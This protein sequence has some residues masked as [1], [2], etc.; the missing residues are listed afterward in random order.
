MA[1]AEAERTAVTAARAAQVGTGNAGSSDPHRVLRRQ[2]A[3]RASRLE[4][5]VARGP[6]PGTVSRALRLLGKQQQWLDVLRAVEV[7]LLGLFGLRGALSSRQ[8]GQPGRVP[9]PELAG[10][11]PAATIA[12]LAAAFAQDPARRGGWAVLV[13]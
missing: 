11:E 6:A 2:A 8:A 5:L 4:R 9:A 7:A 12:I 13:H 10:R 3:G 1:G